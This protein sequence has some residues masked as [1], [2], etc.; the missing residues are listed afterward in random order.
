MDVAI[1]SFG[2]MAALAVGFCMFLYTPAG[3]RW[4]DRNL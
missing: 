1:F 2:L 3:K 4:K